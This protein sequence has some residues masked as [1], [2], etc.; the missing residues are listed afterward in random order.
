MAAVELADAGEPPPDLPDAPRELLGATI[1]QVVAVHRGDDHVLQPHPLDR[2]GEA[3]RLQR[4]EC[5]R[6]AVGNRAVGAVPGA[7]VTQDHK[8]GG[9]V[10]PA[11]ADVGAA[12]LFAHGVEPQLAHH[13]LDVRVAG[14]AGCLHLEPSRFAGEAGRVIRRRSGELY[15]FNQGYGHHSSMG[16]F[17]LPQT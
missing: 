7:D 8:G 2:L 6:R 17:R 3:H 12:G 13:R 10:L 14:S 16:R 1:G 4:V 5:R 9:P 11:F 15:K